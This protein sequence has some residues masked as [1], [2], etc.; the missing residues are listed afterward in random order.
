VSRFRG[1]CRETGCSRPI[2]HRGLCRKHYDYGRN[3]GLITLNSVLPPLERFLNRIEN[4]SESGCWLWVGSLR[5]G[6]GIL[7][8]QGR[9]VSVH[10][11]SYEWFVGPVP[12]GFLLDHLC[13]VRNCVNPDHLEPVTNRE[14]V[15]RGIGPTA[16]NARKTHCIRGHAL[17]G[18][19]LYVNQGSRYCQACFRLRRQ[20]RR[21]GRVA[22]T[23][24]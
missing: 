3:H 18:E 16:E 4:V 7:Y 11:Y 6:Y 13:R 8:A 1:W 21:S 12:Q 5:G 17:T 20:G 14:N 15:L 9:R 22:V 10:R 23:T 19:N 2:T 24:A